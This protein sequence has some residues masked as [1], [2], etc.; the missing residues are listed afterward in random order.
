ML[1]D[2]G[3]NLVLLMFFAA[4]VIILAVG[5]GE[6]QPQVEAVASDACITCHIEPDIIDSMYTPPP[7]AEG[8]GGG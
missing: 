1:K 3:K 5:C 4:F 7:A 2:G 6:Q 8:G